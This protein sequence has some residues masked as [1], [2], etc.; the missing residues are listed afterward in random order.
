[1]SDFVKSLIKDIIGAA[2]LT[3]VVISFV[4]PTIVKQTSMQ[5]TLNPND[6][7]IMYRRAYSGDKEPKRGDIVIF[8]YELQDE[9][10][11][12]KLLIK[13]VIGLPGDKITINDGKVYINDKEY[14]ESYLKDGYTT[15]SVN[16]FKV[17]K[18][19]Y[20]VMGDNRV[21]SIDSRY[22][23]VGCIKKDAIKGRAV[24]RLFPFTKIK[25]L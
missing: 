2:I 25:K 17:P 3:A 1:M 22:S 4:R 18:G 23:E 11:K 13:R 20:F 21:V 12:N 10:G 5:D 16:N 14:D 6:Y 8:K 9:N 15:G 24:L 19:E 7:I